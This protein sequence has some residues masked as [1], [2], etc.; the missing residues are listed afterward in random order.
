MGKIAPNNKV[1]GELAKK[2]C[3]LTVDVFGFGFS[4]MKA[5]LAKLGNTSAA[6]P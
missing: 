6:R 1:I 3:N 5:P 4:C 2:L